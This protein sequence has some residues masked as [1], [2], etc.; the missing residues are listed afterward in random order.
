MSEPE[1]LPEPDRRPGAPHPRHAPRLVG[2]AR[3]WAEAEA[4]LDS[5]ALPHAWLLTGPEGVGKATFAWAFA[6]RLLD[7]RADP[8]LRQRLAA[9]S[10]PRLALLRRGWDH[11]EKRLRTRITIDEVRRLRDA[12][13][14]SV[15]DGG[16]RAIILDAADEMN[17]AAANA[18]LKM[19]EEP[20][21]GAVFL[22]VCHNPSGLLPTI[23]SRCRS[24]RFDPL[25]PDDLAAALAGAGLDT[26]GRVEA[27]AA[28]SGGSTGRAVGLLAEDGLALYDRLVDVLDTCP[29]L[30][31]PAALALAGEVTARGAESR[32]DLLL[33]L[34]DIALARLART[35][36]G[37]PPGAAT[38]PAEARLLA[39]LAPGPAASRAWAELSHDTGARAATALAVNLDPAGIILDILLKINE[40]A[41]RLARP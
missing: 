12:L 8:A 27:V 15:P 14:L 19:L 9:L 20:P 35:G 33:S 36:A 29:A 17:P 39:R 21:R 38:G 13:S 26:G 40:T 10:E 4:A 1:A 7:D 22:V 28:L 41:G 23:R 5:G 18:L 25:A 3:P 11:K 16:R 6:R 37:V 2:H 32:R 31:R 34:V 30:D 24:L